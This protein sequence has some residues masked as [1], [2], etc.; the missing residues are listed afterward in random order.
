MPS[1]CIVKMMRNG[2]NKIG[3]MESYLEQYGYYRVKKQ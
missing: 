3:L 2:A 1:R